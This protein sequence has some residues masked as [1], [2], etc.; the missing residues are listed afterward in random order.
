M[1]GM[2]DAGFDPDQT[3]QADP[4][5]LDISKTLCDAGC[6]FF[7]IFS[8]QSGNRGILPA[9]SRAETGDRLENPFG[10]Q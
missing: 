5:G 1:P 7:R 8:N 9:N 4:V 2:V 10:I 3:F 6:P